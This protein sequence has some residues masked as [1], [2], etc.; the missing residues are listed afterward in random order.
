MYKILTKLHTVADNIWAFHMVANDNGEIVEYASMSK[1]EAAEKALSL[2]ERIGC[3]DLRIVD[4]QSYY[5]NL[6]YGKKPVPEP[7]LY[8]LTYEEIEGYAP[9]TEV[10][11]NIQEG[12]TVVSTLIFDKAITQFHLVVDGKEYK[13]GN[14]AWITYEVISEVEVK[15][16]YAGITRDHTVEVVIDKTE[17]DG[18]YDSI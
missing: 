11:N 2:L 12:A 7:N 15:I 18:G 4:D 3:E 10:I 13:T 6:I 5:L 14:P 1:E 17:E 16:T 8:V 9:D